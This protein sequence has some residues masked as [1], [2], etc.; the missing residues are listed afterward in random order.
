M[1][2]S[3]YALADLAELHA[4]FRDDLSVFVRRH[5]LPTFGAR[6]AHRGDRRYRHMAA[7][8]VAAINADER[9]RDRHLEGA[10][11]QSVWTHRLDADLRRLLVA[12]DLIVPK[13]SLAALVSRPE[14]LNA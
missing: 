9:A 14:H 5:G 12:I 11:D 7:P 10:A 1:D 8:H 2:R 3:A 13:R 4:H 6:L